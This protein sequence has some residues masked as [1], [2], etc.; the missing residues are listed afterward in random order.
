[1]SLKYLK[2][3]TFKADSL[4]HLR[5]SYTIQW[6]V[7]TG[8]KCPG[9]CLD[10]NTEPAS[11]PRATVWTC[12]NISMPHICTLTQE[13]LLWPVKGRISK[14]ELLVKRKNAHYFFQLC[15]FS[16]N[17]VLFVL[18][19]LEHTVC[20]CST[21]LQ[22]KGTRE[23]SLWNHLKLKKYVD[24]I[25]LPSVAPCVANPTQSGQG[26]TGVV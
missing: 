3:F 4:R 5:C 25:L 17:P 20:K 2:Q 1:M 11:I 14:T 18:D 24:N 16:K 9:F 22:A 10:R 19:N 23:T 26:L 6:S 7:V 13:A 21:S 8:C 12:P 15:F